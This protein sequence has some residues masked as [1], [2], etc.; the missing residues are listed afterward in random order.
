MVLQHVGPIV[1]DSLERP[2]YIARLQRLR[3]ALKPGTGPRFVE[4]LLQRLVHEHPSALPI[5]EIEPAF[6][7]L[8]AVCQELKLTGDDGVGYV[9]NL[10]INPE[11]RI[12]LV[13]CKL[14][15][16]PQ[17]VREVVGQILAYASELARLPYDGLVSAVRQTLKHSAG[18]PLM[19]RV[20]GT[21]A[22]EEDRESFIDGVERSLRLGNFLLLIVGDGIRSGVQQIASVLQNATLGFSFGLIEMAIYGDPTLIGPYYVQPRILA[23]TEIITR[24]V[25]I[26]ESE[27]RDTKISKI[28]GGG[29]PQTLSAQE[30]FDQ[31]AKENHEYP[32][33]LRS[34]FEECKKIGCDP[35]LKRKFVLY[36]DD[37]LGGRINLGTVRRDGYV[38]I[39]GVAGHDSQYGEAIGQRYMEQIVG[40]LKDARIKDDF[41]S[42]AN[43][44]IRYQDR[45]AIPL[46]EMLRHQDAWLGAIQEVIERFRILEVSQEERSIQ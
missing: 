22:N 6:G 34:F 32:D 3:R 23:R 33:R 5:M 13:E 29:K 25:F 7:Q 16:N 15:H 18:D 21:D 41:A 27:V 35:Q 43:W 42:P 14:W 24:T 37:H 10:L 44:H 4:N 8:R 26:A 40:F 39:G 19:D 2:I 38:E 36:V 30:F 11:G 46:H 1:I 9:D 31:L 20:L 45:V 17:A 28:E 12:C